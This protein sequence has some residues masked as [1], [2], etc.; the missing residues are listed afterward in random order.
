VLLYAMVTLYII[1]PL[2]VSNYNLDFY[3]LVATILL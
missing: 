2:A 3:L 1:D